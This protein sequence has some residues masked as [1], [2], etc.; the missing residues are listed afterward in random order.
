MIENAPEAVILTVSERDP[1]LWT[2]AA[3]LDLTERVIIILLFAHFAYLNLSTFEEFLD[4]KA[5]LLLISECLPVFLVLVRKTSGD[6]SVRPLDWAFGLAG[7][8]FP[9]LV[10]PT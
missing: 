10:T 9:L 1:R 2:K 6:V 4:I 7:T 5:L 3:L 8:A